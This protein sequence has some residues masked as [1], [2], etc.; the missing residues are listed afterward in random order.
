MKCKPLLPLAFLKIA[1]NVLAIIVVVAFAVPYSFGF[2]AGLFNSMAAGY[3]V[4][5]LMTCGGICAIGN[6]IVQGV[7]RNRDDMASGGGHSTTN[8]GAKAPESPTAETGISVLSA[9]WSMFVDLA[10]GN[11]I[12]VLLAIWSLGNTQKVSLLGLEWLLVF[13]S[14]L[15]ALF[16]V[17]DMG[18]HRVVNW[19]SR[20]LAFLPLLKDEAARLTAWRFI[21]SCV[22]LLVITLVAHAYAPLWLHAQFPQV[23]STHRWIDASML[24]LIWTS[25]FIMLLVGFCRYRAGIAGRALRG[26]LAMLGFAAR[27]AFVFCICELVKMF[28]LVV[29]IDQSSLISGSPLVIALMAIAQMASVAALALA[30]IRR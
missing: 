28:I 29:S 4:G 12:A 19:S 26:G 14:L 1:I 3:V 17:F 10:I 24:H 5:T 20:T 21:L 15:T 23:V 7:C 6:V 22:I 16:M 9:A 25:A 27:L 8:G 11:G 2:A 13:V 18:Q 30:A